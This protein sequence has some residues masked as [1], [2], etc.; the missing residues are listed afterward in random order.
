MKIEIRLERLTKS[1]E[2]SFIVKGQLIVLSVLEL[3]HVHTPIDFEFRL[4]NEDFLLKTIRNKKDFQRLRI[5]SDRS[6]HTEDHE[7]MP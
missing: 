6:C 1:F 2:F 5:L 3:C 4:S 7:Q